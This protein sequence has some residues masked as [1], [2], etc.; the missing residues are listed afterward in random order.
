MG[1]LLGTPSVSGAGSALCPGDPGAGRDIGLASAPG[2]R[3]RKPQ[4]RVLTQDKQLWR[5]PRCC[6]LP[7]ALQSSRVSSGLPA[8]AV[9]VCC[10]PSLPSPSFPGQTG[11]YQ[12]GYCFA[13]AAGLFGGN[14]RE[15]FP[16]PSGY[17]GLTCHDS[18]QQEKCHGVGGSRAASPG[19]SARQLGQVCCCCVLS[20][21]ACGSPGSSPKL[22]RR[23]AE[24]SQGS[25][26]GSGLRKKRCFH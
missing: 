17:L 25:D 4:R 14:K 22:S 23:P 6:P 13:L 1:T 5:P 9:C 19:T 24:A 3:A 21:R 12:P 16:A 18:L 7:A 8:P 26:I 11:V 10:V 15:C 2:G 20:Q